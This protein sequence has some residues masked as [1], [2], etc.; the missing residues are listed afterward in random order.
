MQRGEDEEA[1]RV[2]KSAYVHAIGCLRLRARGAMSS[3]IA[4]MVPRNEERHRDARKVVH[5]GQQIGFGAH[6]RSCRRR[7]ISR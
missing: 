7:A 2:Q 6:A 5:A 3:R 4:I 1:G